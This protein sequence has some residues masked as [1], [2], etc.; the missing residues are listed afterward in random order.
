MSAQ[1]AAKVIL[2][3]GMAVGAAVPEPFGALIRVASAAISAAAEALDSGVA[4]ADLVAHIHRIRHI[5]V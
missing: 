4:E 2:A 1:D 3:V 5:P